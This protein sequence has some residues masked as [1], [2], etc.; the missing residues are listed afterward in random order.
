[1]TNEEGR[2]EYRARAG[3]ESTIAQAVRRSGAR[4]S[5]YKGLEK[6]QLQEVATAAGINLLRTVNFLS[7]KPVGK[8]RISRFARLSQ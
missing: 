3:V 6:T 4:R 7:G 8:T 1:V 5:R 2:R